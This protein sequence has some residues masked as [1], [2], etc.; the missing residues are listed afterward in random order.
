MFHLKL[1]V[2]QEVKVETIS[3][4]RIFQETRRR[5]EE[6]LLGIP[7]GRRWFF[8]H[9]G[10][11]RLRGEGHV[12]VDVVLTATAGPV[13]HPASPGRS[14]RRPSGTLRKDLVFLTFPGAFLGRKKA[15]LGEILLVPSSD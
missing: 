13:P 7:Y 8:F 11:G 14:H 1:N 10:R 5:A 3:L 6:K 12:F 4:F 15:D 2:H 9:P